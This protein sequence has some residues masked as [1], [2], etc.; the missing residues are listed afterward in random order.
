M[1]EVWTLFWLGLY[2]FYI[3][4][5]LKNYCF[6]RGEMGCVNKSAQT[7]I[8]SSKKLKIKAIQLSYTLL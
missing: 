5:G 4:I 3:F 1:L 6:K 2:I 8:I 7:E